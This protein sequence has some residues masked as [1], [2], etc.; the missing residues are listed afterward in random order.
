MDTQVPEEV[1]DSVELIEVT[2]LVS[3]MDI[4]TIEICCVCVLLMAIGVVAG[5]IL[6]DILSRRWSA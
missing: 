2:D 3:G 5:L 4:A 1:L 6:W